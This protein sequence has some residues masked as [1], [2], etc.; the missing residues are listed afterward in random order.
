M[1][2]DP[3]RYGPGRVGARF[4][5]DVEGKLVAEWPSDAV[6][7]EGLER[8]LSSLDERPKKATREGIAYIP[9]LPRI[10][11]VVVGAGHVGRAVAELAAQ[12]DFDVWI[13]DDRRQYCNRERFPSAAGLIVGP[14]EEMLSRLEITSR[15][16]AVIV[17][18]GHGHDQEALH[19]LAPTPAAYVGLI[20]SRR[21]IRMI[22]DELRRVGVPEAALARVAAPI[23]F[24]IG[25]ETVPEIAVSIVAELI[26]RRNRGPEAVAPRIGLER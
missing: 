23:G 14:I 7:P 6:P 8:K 21:K 15:T 2:I 1:L 16:Y 26:A 11:L 17:T 5:F 9:T 12:A 4:L 22:V 24:D 10:R 20:G 18:R 19:L 3:E 25:S 13:V